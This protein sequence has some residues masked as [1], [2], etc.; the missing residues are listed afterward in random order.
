MPYKKIKRKGFLKQILVGLGLGVVVGGKVLASKQTDEEP[1]PQ[2]GPKWGMVIDLDRCTACQSCV[3]A[4]SV[5]NNM[6]LGGP[7]ESSMGRLIRWMKILPRTE[8][9][10]GHLHHSLVPMPC[11]Q[12][13]DP[14]CVRVCPVSATYKSPDGIVGQIYDRCIGCRYCTNACPYTCKFFNWGEPKWPSEMQAAHNPDVSLRDKGVVE[15]CLFCHHRLQRLKDKARAEGREVRDGEYQTACA[16]A[17]PA[18]AITF[19]DMNNPKS[20]VSRAATD[21]RAQTLLEELGVHP[22]VVYLREG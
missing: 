9:K 7:Q 4:C 19:G 5:E 21:H 1:K 20:A 3:V 22:K 17:C 10:G 18:G 12:C 11:Q 2:V 15:K 16:Q 8:K 14:P 13:D 6:M